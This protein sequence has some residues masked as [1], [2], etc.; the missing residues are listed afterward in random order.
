MAENA[1]LPLKHRLEDTTILNDN[2]SSASSQIGN[3]AY[4]KEQ[5]SIP[6]KSMPNTTKNGKSLAKL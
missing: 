1:E 4:Q 3:Q 5:K 2:I 6:N